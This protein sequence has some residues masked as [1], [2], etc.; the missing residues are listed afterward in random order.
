MQYYVKHC[1]V[2]VRLLQCKRRYLELT[3]YS[4]PM[5][6]IPNAKQRQTVADIDRAVRS[7]KIKLSDKTGADDVGQVAAGP[8]KGKPT[9]KH[10]VHVYTTNHAQERSS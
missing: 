3:Q 5:P 8:A 2:H 1:T 10:R 9:L 7:H 6:S 4:V